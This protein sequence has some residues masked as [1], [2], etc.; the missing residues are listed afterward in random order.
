LR[1][2]I[3]SGALP[4]GASLASTRVLAADLNLSRGVV[5]RAYAQLAAEGYL[6]LRRNAAPVVATAARA[7]AP[8][9]LEP[10][11]AIAGYP[12]NLRPDLPD[13][14]LFPR[15]Q[16]QQAV[17]VSLERAA[18]TDLA[19]GEPFGAAALRRQLAPFLA[20]TRGVAAT[21][22]RT[23]V[24]AGSSQALLAIGS[25]LGK[26]GATK[27]A[28]EDPG[29]RWRTRS[30]SASGLEVV[31]VPVDEA[32]LC[33]EELPDVDAVVVTPD[34]QFPLGVALSA[35][36]RRA[37]IDWAVT[38]DRLVIEHD[39]DGHFRHDRPAA[40][41]LQA[42]APEHVAYV[43]SASPLLVPALR[44]G[45]AVLP[46]R[47]VVPLADEQFGSV[48]ATSRL[49]QLALAEFI[50]AG[51]LDRHLRKARAA[52]KRRRQV[53][54]TELAKR[55]PEAVVH[56]APTGLFLSV[57]LAG[58]EAKLLRRA[59]ERGVAIDGFNEH[60]RAPQPDGLALGFAASAEPTL[61]RAIA[62]LA[63]LA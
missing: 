39:Y 31:S 52:Y 22:E 38:G 42:L 33:V 15:A 59:R 27:I 51:S 61:R 26:L 24:F 43:G 55:L 10:D 7:P 36:R 17:R 50:A 60:A 53:A 18:N 6:A 3:A 41:T 12:F 5:V 25:A 8:P 2:L 48:I 16:W 13:L 45:W 4:V 32:G 62:E 56:G 30:I 28:V 35:E 9:P 19:Y 11:V 34:H 20:R 58:A 49:T 40:G 14:G 37:V 57:R 1:G 63:S 44:I 23:G 54:V 29:H 46:A 21:M 47:L